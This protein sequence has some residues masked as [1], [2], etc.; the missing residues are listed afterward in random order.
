[1]RS[2][3][4]SPATP[5][6]GNHPAKGDPSMTTRWIASLLALVAALGLAAPAAGQETPA[7]GG[8][9]LDSPIP[10][11]GSMGPARANMLV[12]QYVLGLLYDRLVY[13][14]GDGRPKPWLAE[15]WTVEKDGRE[16]TFAIR[17]GVT[18]T[19]GTPL[20][21]EAVRYS[22]DRFQKISKRKDLG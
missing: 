6:A 19:D 11:P 5:S 8:R 12:S 18:F 3:P 13:I 2:P 22:L 1:A 16:V 17:K 4:S 7:P 10:A 9:G 14:G 20:D 21:A 15:S